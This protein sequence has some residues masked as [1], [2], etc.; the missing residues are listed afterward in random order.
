MTLLTKLSKDIQEQ[1]GMAKDG[2]EWYLKNT[3]RANPEISM[4]GSN[5]GFWLEV[6]ER[7]IIKTISPSDILCGVDIE[8]TSNPSSNDWHTFGGGSVLLNQNLRYSP[9]RMNMKFT[10]ARIRQ[11]HKFGSSGENP[12]LPEGLRVK[13]FVVFEDSTA[14]RDCNTS[15]AGWHMG[16]AW[17]EVLGTSDGYRYEHEDKSIALA[18][19]YSHNGEDKGNG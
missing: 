5:K 16:A 15:E 6:S 4:T 7:P 10:C 9:V 18:D 14:V 11:N 2:H 12:N 13:V 1:I 8:L 17:F 3:E 19:G